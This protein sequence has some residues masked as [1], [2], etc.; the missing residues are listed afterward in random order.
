MSFQVTIQ[1]SGE[2][3]TVRDGESVLDAALRQGLGM[4]PYGCRDGKCGSCAG[5]LLAGTV[6]YPA[7][8]PRALPGGS[9]NATQALLCQATPC[10]DLVIEPR[11]AGHSPD[12][13]VKSLPCRVEHM[14]KLADDVMRLHLKLPA[15]EPLEFVAGQYIDILLKDGRRRA[16]SIANAPYRQKEEGIELHIRQVPGGIFTTQ[17]FNELRPK[18]LLRIEG[19]LG[20]FCLRETSRRPIIFIA[21]GTGF[22]PIKSIMEHALRIGVQRPMHLF[23]G[24]RARPDLYM[25][26]LARDWAAGSNYIRYTPVLSAATGDE[27]WQGAT[28]WVTDVVA[29]T[30][31]DLGEFEIYMSGPPPM[32]EAG[33]ARFATQGMDEQHVYWDTFVYAGDGNV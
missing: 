30:Y 1:S 10:S 16:F 11:K 4:L 26:E 31:P 3:F 32:I 2:S 25:D 24:A 12:I 7:G 23:W 27:D 33:L 18:S 15:T 22:A 14:K 6:V 17:V 19:P 20:D 13:Q 29:D 21:G 28:G 8:E 5:R 9:A